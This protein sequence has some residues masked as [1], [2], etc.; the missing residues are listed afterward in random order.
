MLIVLRQSPQTHTGCQLHICEI[1]EMFICICIIQH[2]EST[3]GKKIMNMTNAFLES[4]HLIC[5]KHIR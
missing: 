1:R 5:H 3:I 2:F 4:A